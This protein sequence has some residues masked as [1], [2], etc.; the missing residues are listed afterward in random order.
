MDKLKHLQIVL[1]YLLSLTS[2]RL[3]NPDISVNPQHACFYTFTDMYIQIDTIGS[4]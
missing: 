1:I 2:Q 4:G 3:L